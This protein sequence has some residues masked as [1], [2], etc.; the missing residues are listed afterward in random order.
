M[1]KWMDLAQNRDNKEASV[2]IQFPLVL[3]KLFRGIFKITTDTF[4]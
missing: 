1:I 4:L 2:N 3:I